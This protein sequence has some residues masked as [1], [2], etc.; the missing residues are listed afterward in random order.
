MIPSAFPTILWIVSVCQRKIPIEKEK[1]EEIKKNK[2]R[3]QTKINASHLRY[4]LKTL[5]Q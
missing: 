4:I 5:P 2:D 1:K 3:T